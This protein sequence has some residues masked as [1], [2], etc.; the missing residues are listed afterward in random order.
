MS[1]KGLYYSKGTHSQEYRAGQGKEL[2]EL[3][4]L[5]IKQQER[6]KPRDIPKTSEE[7]AYR[8]LLKEAVKPP[9]VKMAE[10]EQRKVLAEAEQARRARK[11]QNLE[12]IA[13]MARIFPE[14]NAETRAML[15]K[16]LSEVARGREDEKGEQPPEYTLSPE[17]EK[18]PSTPRQSRIEKILKD[19]S[20]K[21]SLASNLN[22][23]LGRKKGAHTSTGIKILE[24]Y[25][26]NPKDLE[27]LIQKQEDAGVNIDASFKDEL[28]NLAGE[29]DA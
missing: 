20:T 11:E 21:Q 27:R 26:A 14:N 8:E 9:S 4:Q 15:E 16:F 3:R 29:A 12:D 22:K 6:V 2:P 10:S 18:V 23:L 7:R 19:A 25:L 24:K 1:K 17:E 5:F 28:M 13:Q